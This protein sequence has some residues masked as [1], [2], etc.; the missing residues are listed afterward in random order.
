MTTHDQ[1]LPS[2]ALAARDSTV[3]LSDW[4]RCVGWRI[5][6]WVGTCADHY[7][8]AA[9]YEQLS[10][11]SDTELMRRGLSRST[12]A[13]DVLAACDRASNSAKAN[14]PRTRCRGYENRP[15]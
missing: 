3:T 1:I 14:K 13:R 2:G 8:A 7:A 6:T 11:L 5:M 10:A 9:I 12:L 15:N 4:I